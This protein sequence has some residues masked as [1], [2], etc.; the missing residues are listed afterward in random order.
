[1]SCARPTPFDTLIALWCGDLA[2]DEADAVEEHLFGCDDCAEASDRL[3]KLVGSLVEFVPPVVSRAHVRRLLDR[4]K[5]V[6]ETSVEADATARAVFASNLDLLV[7]VLRGDLSRT[8]RVDVEDLSQDQVPLVSFEGVPFD[9]ETGE[10]LVACQ[11]HYGETFPF[12]VIFR[13]H[14]VEGDVRRRVG[15][16]VYHV[17]E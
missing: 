3:A 13:V 2:A 10:V 11:R 1:M 16:L 6:H 12:D 17:F 4:G 7:H 8:D 9:S 5:R 15:D 14:A